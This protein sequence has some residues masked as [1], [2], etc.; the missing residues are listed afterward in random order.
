MKYI[1]LI[2]LCLLTVSCAPATFKPY[3]PPEIKFNRTPEYSNKTVLAEIKGLGKIKLKP[4]YVDK[5]MKK[6]SPSNADYVILT[7]KNYKDIGVLI[8]KAKAYKSL[9]IEEEILINNYIS[10]IN[11][12]KEYVE[13]ERQKAREYRQLWVMSEN[14]F[15][16]EEYRHTRDNVINKVTHYILVIGGIALAISL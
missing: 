12:Q 2:L 13:L 1:M 15:R 9:A 7:D 8:Q 5:H 4:M 16:M 6:T 11:T 14:N 10:I 3:T